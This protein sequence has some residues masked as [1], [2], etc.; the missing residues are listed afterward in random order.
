MP[1]QPPHIRAALTGGAPSS[2]AICRDLFR[3]CRDGRRVGAAHVRGA[4]P[5]AAHVRAHRDGV[6]HAQAGVGA[7]RAARRVQ[8]ALVPVGHRA[9]GGAAGETPFS[10]H[11]GHTGDTRAG[12]LSAVQ[13]C[14]RLK[15]LT[16]TRLWLVSEIA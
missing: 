2:G 3:G 8:R 16:L 11:T 5:G 12:E 10:R 4:E 1:W 9:A 14:A 6:D 15:F 13:G 7:V